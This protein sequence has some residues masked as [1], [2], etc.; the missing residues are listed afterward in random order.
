VFVAAVSHDTSFWCPMGLLVLVVVVSVFWRCRPTRWERAG[1]GELADR[2]APPR[3]R[4]RVALAMAGVALTPALVLGFARL[5]EQHL[6]AAVRPLAEAAPPDPARPRVAPPPGSS[7]PS[8]AMLVRPETLE[9][10]RPRGST[11]PW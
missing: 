1:D 7:H 3:R 9:G 6:A 11:T 2:F 4:L 10:R 5:S 8:E